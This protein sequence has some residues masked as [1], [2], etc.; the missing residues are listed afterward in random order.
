MK[1]FLIAGVLVLFSNF[2]SAQAWSGSGDQKVQI[3]LSAWGNGTG[4]TGTYDYGVSDMLS[5]GGGAN[6]YFSNYKDDD[7]NNNFFI[8]GR[9]NVHLQEAL[10]LEDKW[11]IYPGLDVG[12]IRN[13]FELGAHIG[14]RYF[15]NDKFGAF[16]E[17]GNNG[18]VGVSINL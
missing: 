14:A 4:I 12:V 16:V 11:D 9:L 7:K 5:V 10:G 17:L 1:K 15:F 13:T 3:G 18:S 6:I 8:F 2:I